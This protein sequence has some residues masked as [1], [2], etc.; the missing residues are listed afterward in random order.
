[1]E[2]KFVIAE[3]FVNLKFFIY[4]NLSVSHIRDIIHTSLDNLLFPVF[5]APGGV[6]DMNFTNANNLENISVETTIHRTITTICN[7]ECRP[8]I[9]HLENESGPIINV[10]LILV[11]ILNS[12]PQIL[13]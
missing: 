4:K 5:T 12:N 8:C 2:S 9:V 7:N 3:Y 6:S 1:M 13:T 11:E 10:H